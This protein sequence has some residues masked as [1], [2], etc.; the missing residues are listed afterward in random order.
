MVAQTNILSPHE[1]SDTLG[2]V[3]TRT[4][5]AQHHHFQDCL[6]FFMLKMSLMTLAIC[7]RYLPCY[8]VDLGAIRHLPDGTTRW[9]GNCLYSMALKT[10]L[11]LKIPN[12]IYRMQPKTRKKSPSCFMVACRHSLFVPL[13]SPE[14]DKLSSDQPNI[15]DSALSVQSTCCHMVVLQLLYFVRNCN[16]W[17]C[18]QNYVIFCDLFT[19]MLHL[20]C[21]LSLKIVFLLLF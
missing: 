11:I 13:W 2:D 14:A 5:W 12:S 4:L 3:E 7:F 18:Y 1:I 17:Y 6:H 21:T 10:P 16:M 20:K 9:I 15:L 8:K 19:L